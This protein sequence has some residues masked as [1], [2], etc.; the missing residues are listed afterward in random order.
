V[1]TLIIREGELE[2]VTF[3]KSF[4]ICACVEYH[5]FSS[6]LTHFVARYLRLGRGQ[7]FLTVQKLQF[8]FYLDC[9]ND[10]ATES[11]FF[12]YTFS[13]TDSFG[14]SWNQQYTSSTRL[15]V[16]LFVW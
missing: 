12:K 14:L 13:V 10:T 15:L 8:G 6:S 3:D 1:D 2:V 4:D 11:W 9:R 7:V 5:Y 16:S